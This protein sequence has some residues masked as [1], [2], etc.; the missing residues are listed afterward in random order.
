MK[1]ARKVPALFGKVKFEV[2]G[3]NHARL[4]EKL[5]KV[6][7]INRAS[8]RG[9]LFSFWCKE[10]DERKIIA[11]LDDLMYNYKI[12][13]K[14]GISPVLARVFARV[15]V[16]L[17]I[18]VSIATLVTYP[19]FVLSITVNDKK[20]EAQ[21]M[22]IMQEMGA[23]RYGF[24]WSLDC[25]N[26]EQKLL[27]LDGVSYAK[28]IRQGTAIA[29]E[30]QRELPPPE[31]L[32]QSGYVVKS[33]KLATVTRT[34]VYSGTAVVKYGDIVKVGEVLIDG[35]ILVGEEKVRTHASG[36]VFGKLY[37]ERKVYF[38]K[39]EWGEPIGRVEQQ[40]KTAQLKVESTLTSGE[41]VTDKWFTH[42]E[43]PD[44]YTVTVK[45]ECEVKISG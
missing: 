20:Y 14:N 27:K 8:S 6:S 26:I 36:E 19:R 44:G 35:Y 3:L 12:L 40:Q 37:I 39:S 16:I 22:E 7:S 43:T 31:L 30:I 23:T 18:V 28:V 42:A 2:E 33:K 25:A 9:R 29:V 32:L 10:K 21:A 24:L 17:G 11:I 13:K 1:K 38:P 45:L 5:R 4:F 15:G 41:I 34:V